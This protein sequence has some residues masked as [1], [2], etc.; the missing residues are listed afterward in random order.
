MSETHSTSKALAMESTPLD[1]IICLL[2]RPPIRDFITLVKTRAIDGYRIDESDLTNEWRDARS[3]LL[4]LES[5][6]S[7]IADNAITES[8]PDDMAQIAKAQLMRPEAQTGFRLLPCA[9][10]MV[11]IDSLVVMQQHI[12]LRFIDQITAALSRSP[13]QNALIRLSVG[14]FH[15]NAPVYLTQLSDSTF[16]V[17]SASSDFRF[18][19][20]A[21]L[22]PAASCNFRVDGTPSTAIGV[23]LGY[24]V[25]FVTAVQVGGRI[26]L[27]NGMH[28]VFAMRSL[29][30]EKIPCLVRYASSEDDLEVIQAADI[31]RNSQMMLHSAR[32]PLFKD[33]FDPRLCKVISSQRTNR[34]F[35]V[36]VNVQQWR[37]PAA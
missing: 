32:P 15:E 16:S 20:I 21:V 7:N 11:P 9:W 34:V 18:L 22:D 3:R 17:S 27:C 1:R 30:I 35:Q 31:Q 26:I 2:G 4:D 23:F 25:N 24:G 13:T 19:K 6:E 29:G 28:R 33:F 36:Q 12:N 8:L 37:T 10:R 5:S 14:T